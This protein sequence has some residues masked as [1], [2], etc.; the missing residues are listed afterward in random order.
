MLPAKGDAMRPTIR[1]VSQAWARFGRDNPPARYIIVHWIVGMGTGVFC[2]AALLV[3]DPLGV[4]S[5][6]FRSDSLVVGLILLFVGFATLFGG[7]VCAAAVM[8]PPPDRAG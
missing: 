5:L 3:L 8:F 1:R 6:L 7:V 2:A 4:R